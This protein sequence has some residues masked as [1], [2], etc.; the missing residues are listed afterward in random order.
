VIGAVLVLTFLAELWSR[1]NRSASDPPDR[2]TVATFAGGERYQAADASGRG[3]LQAL[4]DEIRLRGFGISTLDAHDQTIDVRITLEQ[5]VAVLVLAADS[6]AHWKLRVD[7]AS[8]GPGP[9]AVLPHVDAALRN[10]EGITQLAWH[11]RRAPGEV[12]PAGPGATS[13]LD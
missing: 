5:H 6:P 3:I 8:G 4:A 10:L 1:R 12:Q 7:A 13:P 11:P 2:R 9:R